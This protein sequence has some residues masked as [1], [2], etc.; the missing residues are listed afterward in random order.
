MISHWFEYNLL[1]S[2]VIVRLLIDLKDS[3]KSRSWSIMW[4]VTSMSAIQSDLRTILISSLN[5]AAI[6]FMS[7]S[8]LKSMLRD[9]TLLL[10][11]SASF[12]LYA[13]CFCLSNLLLLF[14][15]STTNFLSFISLR[16]SSQFLIWW[17]SSHRKQLLFLNL[18][19]ILQMKR[20]SLRLK[21]LKERRCEIRYASNRWWSWS[22]WRSSLRLSLVHMT[23]YLSISSWAFF[24]CNFWIKT[25][26]F[27]STW[28][29]MTFTMTLYSENKN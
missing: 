12:A 11:K 7:S 2:I 28:A 19:L 24:F 5:R 17:S 14:V 1:S 26:M 27:E 16:R 23:I 20:S 8:S 29:S 22:R 9:S 25:S 15:F 3:L 18:D 13:F 21:L 10:A 6:F 4:D